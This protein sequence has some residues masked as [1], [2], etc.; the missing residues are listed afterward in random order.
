MDGKQLGISDYEFTTDKKQT[1]REVS[2]RD[3][4]SGVKAGADRIDRA[5]LPQSEQE[6]RAALSAS[7]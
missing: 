7:S 6:G 4:G 2:I 3:G 5:P 1:K